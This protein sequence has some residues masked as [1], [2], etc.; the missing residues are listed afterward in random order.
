MKF[1]FNKW[2]ALLDITFSIKFY[3]AFLEQT[4]SLDIYA[5]PRWNKR[6][7]DTFPF[8][9]KHC[10]GVWEGFQALKWII[11]K[12]M[13]CGPISLFLFGHRNVPCILTASEQSLPC[14]QTGIYRSGL[15]NAQAHR[16]TD[17]LCE[18]NV[19]EYSIL[20]KIYWTGPSL[21]V[22]SH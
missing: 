3:I 4:K 7:L 19:R 18:G 14:K 13:C 12:K 5:F 15:R 22:G 16:P 9:K 10:M 11:E 2:V 8:W 1:Y 21:P 17:H 6:H 20:A